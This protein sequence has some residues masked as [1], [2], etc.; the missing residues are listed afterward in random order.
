MSSPRRS[1]QYWPAIPPPLPLTAGPLFGQDGV[2]VTDGA[3]VHM[4]G[5]TVSS[6]LVNGTGAPIQSAYPPTPDNDPY[7]LGDHAEGNQN[8]RLAAGVRLA[9]AGSS[10]ITDSNITDNACGVL[11][12]TSDGTTPNTATPVAATSDWWGLRTGNVS[13]PN[14]GPAIWTDIAGPGATP[15]PPVPENP[16]NGSAVADSACPPG[17]QDSTAV[18]FCPYRNSDQADSVNGEL[19][20]PDAPGPATEPR[21]CTPNVGLDPNIPSYD[22]FFGTTLG[23]GTTGDGLSGA[24]PSA[25]K[26]GQLTDYM[27]AVVTAINSN[28]STTGQRV[29]AKMVQQGTSVLGAPFY[30]VVIGT[31]G[32]IANLDSGRDDQAFWRGVID[33][34]TLAGQAL[35]QVG[36]RP[37]FAWITGTPHGNEP[38]GGEASARERYELA[39]RT[40]CDNLRVKQWPEAVTQG[41]DC[42]VQNN[43][44]V[45]PP[46]VDQYETAW[47]TPVYGLPGYPVSHYAVSLP[48]IAIYTGGATVPTNPAFHGSGDGYCTT[49]RTY[50]EALSDLTQKEQIPVTQISQLTSADLAN[51]ALQSG[52]YTALI[53][54]DAAIWATAPAGLAGTPAG[55]SG[56]RQ[57]RRHASGHG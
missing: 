2:R 57:R 37:A 31:P 11:N 51:G 49:P 25:K 35:A 21:N 17:V 46:A 16:V 41:K 3:S 1:R 42:L 39:A 13:L 14:P 55:G 22:S 47:Q 33:G 52:G 26:T 34:T 54:P 4:T 28:A 36:K 20:I 23:S 9:G 30:Y 27:H 53:D 50:C 32:N 19:P 29:A 12:T 44:Q 24:T 43:T 8:L 56:V 45:S 5:D 15:N 40:D 7:S 38:A 10:V 48:K 6:N 18:T